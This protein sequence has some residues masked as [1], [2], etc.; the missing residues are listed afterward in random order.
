MAGWVHGLGAA[1]C[2]SSA[3]VGRRSHLRA[4]V[5]EQVLDVELDEGV[6]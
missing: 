3:V 1:V 4:D 6:A 5:L 2:G